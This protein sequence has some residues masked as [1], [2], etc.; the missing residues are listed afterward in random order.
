VYERRIDD[1]VGERLAEYRTERLRVDLT[2]DERARYDADYAM[3][4]GY[5]RS[6]KLPGQYGAK[7]LAELQRRSAYERDARR[8]LL[9]RLRILRLLAGA[10]GKFRV[11]NRLLSEHF[12]QQTL[13]FTE[14]NAVVYEVARRHL[15]PAITHE[16]KSAERKRILEAFRAGQYRAIV[17]S[18]VLNEGI[19]VPSAK[20]AVVLGGTAGAREYVQRLGRVLRKAG[21]QEAVLYE[22]IVRDTVD[23]GR[24]RRRRRRADR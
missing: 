21:N 8:A 17:T 9:A 10:S 3:Y 24:A 13:V 23:E 1:L 15:I 6:N 7:W 20:V 19:D 22:V 16:T 2:P 14:T 5:F 12:H 18:R 11:L 4:A